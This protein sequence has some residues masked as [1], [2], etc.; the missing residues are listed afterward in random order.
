MVICKFF[1][2]GS[3]KFGDRCFNEHISSKNYYDQKAYR[4]DNSG[5][6]DPIQASR[7][8]YDSQRNEP[9]TGFSF[10]RT[11]QSVTSDQRHVN[12]H[13]YQETPRTHGVTQRPSVFSKL[14]GQMQDATGLASKGFSFNKA[15]ADVQRAEIKTSVFGGS[16]LGQSA[17]VRPVVSYEDIDMDSFVQTNQT[18][19]SSSI[20]P[21]SVAGQPLSQNSLSSSRI[22]VSAGVGETSDSHQEDAKYSKLSLLTNQAVEAFRSEIFSFGNIPLC[23]PPIELC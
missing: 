17:F 23:P 10:N 11:L 15:L 20:F 22:Q 2:N 8:S 1:M 18:T 9:S 19:M 13:T 16:Q 6:R 3:C 7:F 5:N 21:S 4:Q 14:G 12:Y